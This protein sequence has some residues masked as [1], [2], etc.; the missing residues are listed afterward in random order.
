MRTWRPEWLFRPA[1]VVI[2]PGQLK[3]PLLPPADMFVL[4]AVDGLRQRARLGRA[5][6]TGAYRALLVMT[7]TT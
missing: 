7:A 2:V 5:P 4:A 3:A 1:A 6:T